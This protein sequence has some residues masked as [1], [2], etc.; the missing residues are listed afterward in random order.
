[1]KARAI[2]TSQELDKARA[3][4][5]VL[6]RSAKQDPKRRFHALYQHVYRRDILERAWQ[7][8]RSNR[9]ASGVDG[10]TLA[11]IET[12]GVKGF[13]DRLAADLKAQTYRAAPLRRVEIPKSGRPGEFRPLSIPCVRDRVVM[14]AAKI[15]LEPVFEADFVDVSFGFRPRRSA[16]DACENVFEKGS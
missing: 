7:E 14:T 15:V 11:D 5:H 13:L 1:M 3:L 12:S 4:Q 9:G 8:V 2:R 6:Y 16:H 10:V